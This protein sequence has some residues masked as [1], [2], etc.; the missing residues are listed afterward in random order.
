MYYMT[1][2]PQNY[3]ILLS[4]RPGAS[5]A[6]IKREIGLQQARVHD[7][8]NWVNTE[9]AFREAWDSEGGEGTQPFWMNS[10]TDN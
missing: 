4:T 8:K 10:F 5:K 3:H 6:S 7:W 1:K 2:T 9:F